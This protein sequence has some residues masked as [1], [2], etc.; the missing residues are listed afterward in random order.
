MPVWVV[1]G[2][3]EKYEISHYTQQI[4]QRIPGSHFVEWPNSGHF[5]PFQDPERFAELIRQALES[6]SGATDTG[7]SS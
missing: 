2:K 7:A 1:R 6:T 3:R 4:Q 5:G